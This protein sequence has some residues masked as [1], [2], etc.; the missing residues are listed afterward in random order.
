MLKI[1]KYIYS[2]EDIY[3]KVHSSTICNSLKLEITQVPLNNRTED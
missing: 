1:V 2:S 3:E